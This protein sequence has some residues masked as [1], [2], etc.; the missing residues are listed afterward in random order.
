MG[1][2]NFEGTTNPVSAESWLIKLECIFEV[3]GCSDDQRVTFATF[4]FLRVVPT[5]GGCQWRPN[6]QGMGHGVIFIKSSIIISS[7]LCIKMI[8]GV[9]F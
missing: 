6:I 1:A 7:L 3:M 8:E 9:S 5:T 4:F 2:T